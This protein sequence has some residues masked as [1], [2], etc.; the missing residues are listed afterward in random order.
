MA[1]GN[2]RRGRKRH[3]ARIF[4]EEEQVEQDQVRE[5]SPEVEEEQV[6]EVPTKLP[7]PPHRNSETIVTNMVY[8]MQAQQKEFLSEVLKMLRP[9]GS[10]PTGGTP[11]S[12]ERNTTQPM[13]SSPRPMDQAQNVPPPHQF[14]SPSAYPGAYPYP[15]PW[16]GMNTQGQHD[17]SRSVDRFLKL[18]PSSFTGRTGKPL[19]PAQWVAEMEKNFRLMTCTEEEKVL[20]ATHM[21][22]E[23]A[24]AWWNSTR[25]YL[26][27]KYTLVDWEVFKRAFFDKY[28]PKSFR[29]QMKREFLNLQQSQ[30]TV[31]AY[32]QRYEELFFFAPASMQEEETKTRRFTMGLRGSIR[33]HILGQDKKIYNEAVQVARVIESSQRDSFFAQNKGV[34]RPASENSGGGNNRP[35]RPYRAQ[36]ATVPARNNAA[37]PVPQFAG[38][39]LN[40]K[41]YNCQQLGHVARNCTLPKKQLPQEGKVYAV[42]TEEAA[43]S[44][45]VVTASIPARALFDSGTTHSFVSI[46]FGKR[47]ELPIKHLNPSLIVR[48]PLR[49]EVAL[50]EYYGPCTV[51]IEGRDLEAS[52]V[53]LEVADFDVILGMDW[54][55]HHSTVLLCGERKLV[56]TDKEGREYSFTGIKLSRKRKLI[57]SALKAKRCLEKGGVG[58]LVS[59]VDI[60]TEVPKMED[61]AVVREFPDVFPEDLPGLPPDRATEFVI[62]LIPGS[63]SVSKAPYRMAPTELK[64]LKTQLQELLDKGFIRPSI[65]P[66]GAPVLFV[67]KKDGNVR[68]CIDYRELNKLTIKN[69]YPLPRIDDLFDQLQGAKVFSKIDLR[70]RY[71]QLKIK[72]GDIRRSLRTR[73]GHYEFLVMSFGLTNAPASFME[74]MNRVFH[75]ML[76][77]RSSYSSMTYWSIQRTWKLIQHI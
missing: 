72:A 39:N 41:C 3:Q 65:S 57:L 70:S 5:P 47:M 13:Q 10:V 25:A 66:W 18:K 69:R 49:V 31:D 1:G 34:K 29:D 68:L 6:P 2:D 54:L 48:S 19:W 38:H 12:E 76:T 21:L 43:A 62:D 73:Y 8:Q 40:I 28:F 64:E 53:I 75:D 63:A 33:E 17:L 60:T 45:D 9:S 23:D 55:G 56:L 35:F 46:S 14:L 30:S 61:L 11:K 27:N 50:T 15:P 42:T 51:C 67:K 74:L 32:Q 77:L 24:N 59:V 26:E 22:K 4:L 44:Q 37:L 16:Y 71:H 20:F 58:Y 36:T 52:L 7:G